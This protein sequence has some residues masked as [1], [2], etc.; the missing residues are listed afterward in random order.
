MRANIIVSFLEMSEHFG[1][2]YQKCINYFSLIL[3]WGF[4]STHD[5][6]IKFLSGF[7]YSYKFFHLYFNHSDN[8]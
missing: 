7:I 6:G 2:I 4:K 3:F 5:K 8:L 1:L